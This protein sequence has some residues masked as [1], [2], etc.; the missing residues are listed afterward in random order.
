MNDVGESKS[1]TSSRIVSV[2]TLRG[3]TILL[4][5]FVNDLGPA[6]PAWVHHIQPPN[7]DG[8]TLADIVF[9]FFL[10]IVGVSIPLAI[11]TARS[12]GESDLK[13][14]LHI[15]IRTLGLLIMGL[16]GVNRDAQTSTSP[17]LW[18]LLCYVAIILA[19]CVVP[20]VSGVQRNLFL[21][22]KVLGIIGL[23]VL[24]A[25]YRREPVETNV[26]FLGSVTEWTWL[27]TQWWGILG[28][29]GWAYFASAC[30]YLLVAGRREWIAAAAGLLM[31]NFVVANNGGFFTR[32]DDKQWLGP[33]RPLV[34][35][36]EW[37]LGGI[38]Q[39]VSLGSQLGSL[40]AIVMCGSLLG[41]ILLPNSNVESPKQRIRWGLAFSAFLFVAGAMTDTF[42]GVNK[43]AAT[44]TWCFW[45]ASLATLAWTVLYWLMDIK[46]VT[47]WALPFVPVGANPLIAYLL[48][49]VLLFALSL[50]GLSTTIRVYA[51]SESCGVAILGSIAMAATVCGLTAAIAKLGLRV[52]I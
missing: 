32:L 49:P 33:V 40:P 2:D 6:A 21:G 18:G 50:S 9:P 5:V 22:L 41:T 15:V 45:C 28:L 11:E 52:R 31:T 14:L 44:P 39:Y 24:L 10:F 27:Q 42:A 1:L 4:M 38:D 7:A 51:S 16:V 35:A 36:V 47:W 12:R 34:D 23:V 46:K 20:R 43:I 26:L 8:M 29:I 48:H 19:W 37:L 30:I 25:I 17:A 13:I 3:L